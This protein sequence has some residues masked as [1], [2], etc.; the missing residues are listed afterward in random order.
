MGGGRCLLSG[1][2]VIVYIKRY[3]WVGGRCS[4]LYVQ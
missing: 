3:K 2:G 1:V 4:W